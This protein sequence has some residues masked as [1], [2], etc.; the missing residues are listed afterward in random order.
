MKWVL[1]LINWGPGVL[2][3]SHICW[4]SHV[5]TAITYL[6]LFF[7]IYAIFDHAHKSVKHGLHQD[8]MFAEK[9]NT[10]LC[11]LYKKHPIIPWGYHSWVIPNNSFLG[12]QHTL[13]VGRSK[14]TKK[15]I[16]NNIIIKLWNSSN[17]KYLNSRY[18]RL[19]QTLLISLY[20]KHD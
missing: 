9:R 15:N 13:T 4:P 19:Q 16:S 2:W 20:H 5:L 18:N 10:L 12:C 6:S 1:W 11:A 14:V 17:R 8:I 7:V 3:Q